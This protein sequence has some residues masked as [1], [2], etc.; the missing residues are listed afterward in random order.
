M[1]MNR[2]G[3]R[4]VTFVLLLPVVGASACMREDAS[5]PAQRSY[6]A[7]DIHLPREVM[8]VRD[9]V[10]RSTTLYGLLAGHGVDTEGVGR[11]VEAVRSV[12]DPRRLRTSQPFQLERTVRGALRLFEYEIDSESFLRVAPVDG[13]PDRLRAE[14]LPIPRTLEHA[15]AAGAIDRTTSSLYAAMKA[16]G[17][18]DDLVIKLAGVFSGEIDFN[19]EVQLDDRF[20]V[21]FER[22]RRDDGGDS[23]YGAITA[24]EFNGG[25]RVLRAIRFT[26]PGGNPDYYDEQGRS[27]R[28]FFLKSPLEFNPRITSRFSRSRMHPVLNS[29]RAHRGVDYGAP[30]G[31]PVIAVAAGT[32]VS[33]TY[34]NANGRMVRLRHASGYQTYYLHLSRFASG[35]RAGSRVAQG[36][37]IGY[38]GSTGLATGPHLHYGLTKNGTFVDPIAEHRRMPPGDPIPASAMAD[39]EKVRD[40]ALLDLTAAANRMPVMQTAQLTQ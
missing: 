23:T 6:N 21:A 39:F 11:V 29:R 30:T 27:L 19:S 31:A 26:P 7:A 15:T 8:M 5:E 34:D 40:R 36:T 10:P 18:G 24:A 28:R 4:A 12:F 2:R 38:V 20:A 25:G 35:I 22:F 9:F 1:R 32:V 33:A 14:V 13:A 3:F 37:V 17:E 16:A